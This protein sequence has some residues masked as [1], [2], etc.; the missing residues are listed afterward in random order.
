MVKLATQ[1]GSFLLGA[2]EEP[3]GQ[4]Y[5][6]AIAEVFE[7]RELIVVTLSFRPMAAIHSFRS[8]P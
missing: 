5:G 3:A 7:G 6:R 4:P 1:N 2:W 8:L